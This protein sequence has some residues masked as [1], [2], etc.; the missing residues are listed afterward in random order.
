MLKQ[1]QRQGTIQVKA[2]VDKVF[3]LFTPQGEELWVA[4]WQPTYLYPESGEVCLN[5]VFTT[6][7]GEIETLWITALYN[8][9]QY[10][11]AYINIVPDV[12]VRRVDVQC[13]ALA[14]NQTTVTVQYIY[15][16]LSPQGNEVLAH[17]TAEHYAEMM[18]AWEGAVNAIL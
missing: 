12:V 15:T 14:D 11:A 2:N 6:Q 1:L 5:S 7:H 10:Q 9:T 8:P 17:I 4:G 16:A 18:D 3:P 13:A